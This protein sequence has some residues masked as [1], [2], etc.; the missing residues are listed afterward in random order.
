[1]FWVYSIPIAFLFVYLFSFPSS[2]EKQEDSAAGVAVE[3]TGESLED[4]MAK[5]KNM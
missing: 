3:D 1:M 5:M 4:L 2:V